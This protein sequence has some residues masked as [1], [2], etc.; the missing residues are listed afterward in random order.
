MSV[1][2]DRRKARSRGRTAS[3]VLVSMRERNAGS[4]SLY[5]QDVADRPIDREAWA[6]LIGAL[7][8]SETKGKKATFA[9]LVGVD[10]KTI[11]HWLAGAVDVSEQSVRRVATATGR[12]PMDLLV[13]VGYYRQEEVSRP[14]PT[15][16]EAEI[17]EVIELV[18]TDDKLSPR[19]KKQI[20]DLILARRDRERAA[21]RD[22]VQRLIDAF[23]DGS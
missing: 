21:E 10:P 14:T 15:E 2:R 18:A 16:S 4:R 8:D 19:A 7:I 22:E 20:I 23:K 3:P 9:R 1:R 6:A 13:A 12:P 5:H 11:G 17:D